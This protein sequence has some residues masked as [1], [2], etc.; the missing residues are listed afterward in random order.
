M[1]QDSKRDLYTSWKKVNNILKSQLDKYHFTVV[2]TLW[3]TNIIMFWGDCSVFVLR[4]GIQHI[5]KEYLIVYLVGI[6]KATCGCSNRTIHEL[7]CT[8][9]LTYYKMS[10]IAILLDAIVCNS[11]SL[12]ENIYKGSTRWW[13]VKIRVEHVELNMSYVMD[14]LWKQFWILNNIG[15]RTL[16]RYMNLHF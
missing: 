14:A 10:G 2:S 1:L 7:P 5:A 4:K 8:C 11:Y 3:R 13:R 16:K 9:L 12:E 6:D 15:K